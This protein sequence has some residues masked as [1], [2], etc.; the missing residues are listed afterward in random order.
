VILGLLFASLYI[1]AV[2]LAW[3]RSVAWGV[4]LILPG[5]VLLP[6]STLI[7]IFTSPV[8][9]HRMYL[10]AAFAVA[11]VVVASSRFVPRFPC[12]AA[13]GVWSLFAALATATVIRNRV[14]LSE[15]S[16]WADAAA[17]DP[18]NAR[19][20]NN[21]G[22]A[23]ADEGKADEGE[24]AILRALEIKPGYPDAWYNL[25][26]IQGRDA[27]LASAEESFKRSISLRSAYPSA[28]C[29]L[30]VVLWRRG[31]KEAAMKHYEE[32]IRLRPNY[33]VAN[34]NL[35]VIYFEQGDF[36]RCIVHLRRCLS[37]NP[38]YPTALQLLND[39][40]RRARETSSSSNA[41]ETDSTKIFRQ[42]V[43]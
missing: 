18:Q 29:N 43:N 42:Q 24:A 39:A 3:R 12:F 16:V 34:F 15:S 30:A 4:G 20:L 9:D 26:T 31:Q 7:P 38:D 21:L 13:I 22:L 5:L 14:F 32:A 28:H 37:A 41:S 23:L 35:A 40:E 17:Q 1:G 10:P 19:A 25:G 33:P 36:A 8:A 11:L 27:R 6:T 2:V